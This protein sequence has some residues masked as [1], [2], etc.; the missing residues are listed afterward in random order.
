MF[1]TSYPGGCSFAILHLRAKY[2]VEATKNTCLNSSAKIR[3]AERRD[4]SIRSLCRMLSENSPNLV[5]PIEIRGL[6]GVWC[7]DDE[8]G[9]MKRHLYCWHFLG[10]GQ[11]ASEYGTAVACWPLMSMSVGRLMRER[12]NRNGFCFPLS[13]L[14]RQST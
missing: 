5:D 12:N 9:L 4:P 3:V 10:F 6:P 13:F 7:V 8:N 11:Q 14:T 1:L 2:E